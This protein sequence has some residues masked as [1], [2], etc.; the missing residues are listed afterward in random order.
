M[1]TS[2]TGP[3]GDGGNTTAGIGSV[4]NAYL[5]KTNPEWDRLLMACQKNDVE[6]VR[7]L[8][9]DEGV[10]PSHANPAGQSALHIAAWWAHVDCLLLLLERGANVHASNFLT[11]ATPLHGCIQS[12]K[13]SLVKSRR[14]QCIDLLLQAGADPDA[15]DKLGKR[16]IDYLAQNDIDRSDIVM[17]LE[18]PK[19]TNSIPY[20]NFG[21]LLHA[22]DASLDHVEDCWDTLTASM[23]NSPSQDESKSVSQHHQQQQHS[24]WTSMMSPEQVHQS[25]D[26]LSKNILSLLQEWV[27]R[28]EEKT[29]THAIEEDVDSADDSNDGVDVDCIFYSQRAGW[30]WHRMMEL[31]DQ[32]QAKVDEDG[33][34]DDCNDTAMMTSKIVSSTRQR[35]LKI[36]GTEILHRYGYVC[37]SAVLLYDDPALLSMSQ[38][39]T[40]LAMNHNQD[41]DENAGSSTNKKSAYSS[42]GSSGNTNQTLSPDDC[43]EQDWMTIARR[44]YFGLAELWWNQLGISPVGIV[45]RQGMTALQ[46]AARSGH[47]HLV[48]WFLRP[49]STTTTTTRSLASSDES[50]RS[51]TIVDNDKND[52]R[53]EL[54]DWVQHQ[55]QAGQTALTAAVA[56]QHDEVVRFL[57]EYINSASS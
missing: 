28:I 23:L 26:V 8:L 48:Q 54:L 20:R 55:D 42:S 16:P 11:G 52:S 6:F 38:V 37:N 51:S 22:T 33:D 47:L 9:V 25:L 41:V 31:H 32:Q 14:L 35:G 43:L 30:I 53:A 2:S 15:V 46:F 29:S 7:E 18:Q 40:L 10:N 19:G 57:E 4:F 50:P 56:N 1:A 39:A 36:L 12:S 21:K 44:N 24:Q 17:R 27:D 3:A 13:A 49:R 5:A 45:N 34:K